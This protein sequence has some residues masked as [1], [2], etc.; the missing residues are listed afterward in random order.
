MTHWVGV[1]KWGLVQFGSMPGPLRLVTLA[2]KELNV[3]AV[4]KEK[5]APME[6]QKRCS[7]HF[8]GVHS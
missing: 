2:V 1:H 4:L 3:A 6:T 7:Q 5:P 8:P